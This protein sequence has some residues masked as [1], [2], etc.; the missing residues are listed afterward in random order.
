MSKPLSDHQCELPRGTWGIGQKA[1]GHIDIAQFSCMTPR[2][3]YSCKPMFGTNNLIFA[4]FW[5][6]SKAE[7]ERLVAA[8]CPLDQGRIR[9][10]LK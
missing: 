8:G 1:A 2:G 3:C 9:E 5:A 4:R 7:V 6:F 10:G